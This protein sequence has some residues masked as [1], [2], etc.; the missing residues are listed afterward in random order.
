V[1]NTKPIE[2][3]GTLKLLQRDSTARG[4][5]LYDGGVV[6]M[7]G[8]GMDSGHAMDLF[9]QPTISLVSGTAFLSPLDPT[10]AAQATIIVRPEH[11]V[12][13]FDVQSSNAVLTVETPLFGGATGNTI[14]KIGPGTLLWTGTNTT[15]AKLRASA[16]TFAIGGAGALS[17]GGATAQVLEILSGATFRY[18]SSASQT[19]S[20][21]ITCSGT[22]AKAGTGR[23]AITGAFAL[24]AGGVLAVPGTDASADA[25][26]VNSLSLN[27]GAIRASNADSLR[28]GKTYTLLTSDSTL[29]SG[30]LGTV[31]GLGEYWRIT[32]S[33]DGKAI[34][35]YKPTGTL[36]L[37]N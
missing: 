29:P 6:L 12:K 15:V 4:I 23:L 2:V 7:K 34:L 35:L 11:P 33:S 31:A 25:V 3:A 37:M 22:F 36:L 16:G 18:A 24:N 13:T 26:K 14:D 10:N 28:A 1:T 5:K 19:L 20:G 17:A 30:I 9:N 32:L 27:G 21:A 8:S